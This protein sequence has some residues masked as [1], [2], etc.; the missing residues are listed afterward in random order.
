MI[1]VGFIMGLGMAIS[2]TLVFNDILPI[3]S[4]MDFLGAT[5]TFTL[6]YAEFGYI[7]EFL[8]PK[9]RNV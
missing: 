7:F 1:I 2:V 8:L 3:R 5:L 6:I 9:A 4:I